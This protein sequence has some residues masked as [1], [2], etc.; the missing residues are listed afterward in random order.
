M[1]RPRADVELEVVPALGDFVPAGA[2]LLR[3][4]GQP[5]LDITSEALRR[6]S[7]DTERSLDQDLAY[8][9]RLLVDISCGSLAEPFDPTTAVQAIDCLHD[10]L[11]QLVIGGFPAA[12]PRPKPALCG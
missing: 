5:K 3:I 10:F 7:L 6:I 11:R 1:W 9:P 8:G 12:I 4:K 2:P